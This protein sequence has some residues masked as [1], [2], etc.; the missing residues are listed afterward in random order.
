MSI[1]PHGDYQDVSTRPGIRARSL[2][3]PAHGITDFFLHENWLEEG[4][5]IPLHTHPVDEV[6]IVT[7][8]ALTVEAGGD[9]QVVPGGHTVV[10]PPETP[11]R[12]SNHG[13]AAVHMM[14]AAAWNHATFYR[15]GTRYLE[16]TPRE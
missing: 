7:E 11:H 2:I 1:Y 8:G 6:V 3:G 14:A 15:E 12:L 16:G 10:I 5:A 4:A 9:V 13:A